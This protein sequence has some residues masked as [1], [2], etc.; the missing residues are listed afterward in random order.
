MAGMGMDSE[1][2]WLTY[3]EASKRIPRSERT[4]RKWAAAGMPMGWTEREGQRVRV[5]ELAVLQKWFR[6]ALQSSPVHQYRLRAQDVE[7]GEAPRDLSGIL[8]RRQE[9]RSE[10]LHTPTPPHT[11]GPP[12][13]AAF[14]RT[15]P[16][17]DPPESKVDQQPR[18]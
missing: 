2:T 3:R 4:I 8:K 10:T 17:N 18:D 13:S 5:V 6:E 9:S 7:R 14:G 12:E 16:E 15:E 11:P 1:Q